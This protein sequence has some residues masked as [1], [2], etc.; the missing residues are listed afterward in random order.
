MG[1]GLRTAD[2]ST[3]IEMLV[4]LE[5]G[6]ANSINHDLRPTYSYSTEMFLFLSPYRKRIVPVIYFFWP[7]LFAGIAFFLHIIA[8]LSV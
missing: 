8:K 5:R 3:H 1:G 2:I 7:F 4:F 6:R